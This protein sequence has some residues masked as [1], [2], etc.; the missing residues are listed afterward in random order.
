MA[1]KTLGR[2]SARAR[3]ETGEPAFFE[4]RPHGSNG[5]A[6]VSRRVEILLHSLFNH[7]VLDSDEP[8]LFSFA[9]VA[10]PTFILITTVREMLC[11]E[12]MSLQLN[13]RGDSHCGDASG[14]DDSFAQGSDRT[15]NG[16]DAVAACY[17][18]PSSMG[19]ID[20]TGVSFLF[21]PYDVVCGRDK[22]AFNNVGN[23]RFRITVSLALERFMK[24]PTRKAKS[25]VIRSVANLVRSNGGRFLQPTVMTRNTP[26]N[27]CTQQRYFELDAKQSRLKVGHALRDLALSVS[28][29]EITILSSPLS[30]TNETVVLESPPTPPDT[31]AVIPSLANRPAIFEMEVPLDFGNNNLNE[32]NDEI[33]EEMV[34][35]VVGD[36]DV[37][38]TMNQK[39]D[40]DSGKEDLFMS[41][42]TLSPP[43]TIP[44]VG[45]TSTVS[46]F[47]GPTSFLRQ[48]TAEPNTNP[49]SLLAT[50]ADRDSLDAN[51]LSW[52]VDE[53]ATLLAGN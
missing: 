52:L 34:Q 26:K 29:A 11:R 51:I 17:P 35:M 4:H 37:D 19:A 43:F 9:C 45:P 22:I 13:H 21:Q 30:T 1:R 23:R 36:N 48:V 25:I 18:T 38:N 46:K 10:Y 16:V 28:R 20:L 2:N 27:S 49:V 7:T 6:T 24:S 50:K 15:S 53:S 44:L 39:T 5:L 31:Y 33:F 14:L 3:L 47:V 8:P 12:E 40:V 32:D 41:N 42:M